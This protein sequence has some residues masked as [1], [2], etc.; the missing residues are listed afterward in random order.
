M[1]S[2]G[3]NELNVYQLNQNNPQF[4]ISDSIAYIG[5]TL[6]LIHISYIG[7]TKTCHVSAHSWIL[8]CFLCDSRWLFARNICCNFHWSIYYLLSY[9]FKFL[10][11]HNRHIV[12]KP[13]SYFPISKANTLERSRMRCI[14]ME[15]CHCIHYSPEEMAAMI[16][17]HTV[18]ALS[19]SG[20]L[21]VYAPGV[22]VTKPISSV[23][24]FSQFFIIVKTYFSCYISRLYLTG[25]AAAQ[26]RGHLSN[27]NVI[28]GI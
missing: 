11:N 1:A 3:H 16:E 2:L 18:P 21:T 24:L 26:L 5:T 20:L 13:L 25:V 17:W 7:S 12:A 22:G 14:L 27:I 23:P 8:Q 19:V 4:K 28:P 15:I 10:I 6:H 9:L